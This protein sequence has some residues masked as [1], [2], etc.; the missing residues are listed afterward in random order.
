MRSCIT[1][2]SNESN[3][4]EWELPII[5]LLTISSTEYCKIPFIGPSAAACIAAFID[6][7]VTSE[8]SSTTRSTMLPSGMGTRIAR[9]S[10]LPASSGI[11]RPIAFAA[12]VEVGTILVAALRERRLSLAWGESIS[13][14]LKSD[15]VIGRAQAFEAI[16]KGKE[17]PQA[18]IPE[19]FNVLLHELNGLGLKISFE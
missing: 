2:V 9:P 15:D 8:S 16:V 19:S 11:T 1:C 5:S 17:L 7:T 14:T 6:S 12:P 3:I 18:G 10:S 4:L 13:R